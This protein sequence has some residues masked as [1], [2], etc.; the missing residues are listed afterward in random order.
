MNIQEQA[1][2]YAESLGARLLSVEKMPK[3]QFVDAEA[4]KFLQS[5][6]HY[7]LTLS[8]CGTQKLFIMSVRKT[9]EAS[10]AE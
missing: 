7:R 1:E 9:I 10:L 2:Q 8:F 6:D 3:Y 5:H 4:E